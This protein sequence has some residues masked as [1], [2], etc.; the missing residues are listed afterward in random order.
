MSKSCMKLQSWQFFNAARR[1]LSPELVTSIF[2]RRNAR[3]AYSWAQ[4]PAYTQERC[5]DPL[6][7]LKILCER[8]EE[9]G[10]GD[11]VRCAVAYLASTL[12]HEESLP[13][14]KELQQTIDEELLADYSAVA[15]LGAM[16]KAGAGIEELRE[17]T[18]ETK[19]EIDRTLAKVIEN[20]S[21]GRG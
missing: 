2:G 21:K 20:R 8:L 15:D 19:A 7:A 14:V 12:D 17:S 11:L 6:E 16:I 1:A 13:S 10:R 4:D 18:E 5:R 3:A 9:I